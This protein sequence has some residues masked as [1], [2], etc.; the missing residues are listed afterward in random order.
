MSGGTTAVTLAVTAIA[1]AASMYA[2]YQGQKTQ[3]K[4][5]K[6]AAEYN[7]QV[8]E[9]EAAA[10]EQLAR[11]EMSKGIADRERQQR[12]AARQMGEMRA[13]MGASGFE[14]DTG[15]MSSLLA[16]SAEEHQY[17]SNVIMQNAAQAA[18]QHMVGVTAADNNKSF[19]N[20]QESNADSG[21]TGSYLGMGGTILGGISSGI[22]AYNSLSQTAK[23]ATGGGNQYWDR[24]LGQY[25]STPV[26][27]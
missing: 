4:S 5:A 24:A 9:N 23:P 2:Q 17:D 27:H 16:E 18:W 7:A 8:A 25:T 19:A 26:R 6:A 22:G 12:A 20:W 10:Q 14:M 21:R 15:S 11:N 13:N 1:T 3:E